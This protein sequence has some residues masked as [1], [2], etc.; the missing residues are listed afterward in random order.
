[1]SSL[2]NQW[3][4]LVGQL[5]IRLPEN[6]RHLW[7]RSTDRPSG[8]KILDADEARQFKAELDT[9]FNYPGR[10]WRGVPFA[11]STASEDVACF[12]LTGG[13]DA[14]A[15]VIPVRDW[16]GPRWEFD[17]KLKSFEQWLDEDSK[18]KIT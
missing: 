11:R 15:L 2:V 4:E 5:E 16:H 17:G 8:W 3:D 12:D 1:M 14:E 10:Q 6:F 7:E 13:L 9:R 18:G